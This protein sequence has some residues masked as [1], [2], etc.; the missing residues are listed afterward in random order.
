MASLGGGNQH[1]FQLERF[2][3][4]A[5]YAH[6][7][8]TVQRHAGS[9]VVDARIVLHNFAGHA[10]ITWLGVCHFDKAQQ[11]LVCTEPRPAGRFVC[12]D[13]RVALCQD[14]SNCAHF[15]GLQ[16]TLSNQK[17]ALYVCVCST[18]SHRNFN[19]D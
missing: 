16:E 6:Y 11:G 7:I 13:L 9:E 4:D 14:E 5:N 3:Y 19:F 18:F 8:C 2:N 10:D 1:R 12:H 15:G 17:L